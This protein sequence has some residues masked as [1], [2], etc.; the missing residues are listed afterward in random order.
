M[1]H[2]D[3]AVLPSVPLNVTSASPCLRA[4]ASKQVPD[5]TQYGYIMA[6]ADPHAWSFPLLGPLVK[7]NVHNSGNYKTTVLNTFGY[8]KGRHTIAIYK[9]WNGDDDTPNR[10]KLRDLMLGWW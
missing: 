10:L 3:A 7:W 1:G 6:E 9:A 2:T 4:Q 8:V 5:V